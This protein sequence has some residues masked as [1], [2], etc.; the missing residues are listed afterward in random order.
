MECLQMCQTTF[1]D[2]TGVVEYIKLRLF[3]TL[4]RVPLANVKIELL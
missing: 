4:Y 2:T 3:E 1:D